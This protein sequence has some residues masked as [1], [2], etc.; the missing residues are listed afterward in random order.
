MIKVNCQFCKKEYLVAKHRLLLTKYCSRSCH[1]SVSGKVGG[2]NGKGVSRNKGVKRPYLSA[3]NKIIKFTG[4]NSGGWRGDNVGY[5]GMHCWLLKNYKKTGICEHCLF[6][7]KTHWANKSHNYRREDRTDWLELCSSCHQK[8][9]KT[10]TKH[11]IARFKNKKL[12][13]EYVNGY[14]SVQK[15]LTT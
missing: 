5:E 11:I 15:E 8:Y 2:T 3:R 13:P 4:V 6:Q 10:E 1:G 9:D 12:N 7:K 14:S